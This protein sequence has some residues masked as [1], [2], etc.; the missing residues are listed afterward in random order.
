M[1]AP[2][3]ALGTAS[4]LLT[5]DLTEAQFQQIG[6]V[7]AFLRCTPEHLFVAL[8]FDSLESL[9]GMGRSET[10][11][12][13]NDALIDH[14]CDGNPSSL[15]VKADLGNRTPAPTTAQAMKRNRK[16][17]TAQPTRR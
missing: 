5:V 6:K 15:S 8:A 10:L 12:A 2:H 4:R 11:L 3:D 16:R 17:K 7:A 9:A 14:V 1:K 13:L